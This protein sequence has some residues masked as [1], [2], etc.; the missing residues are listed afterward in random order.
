MPFPKCIWGCC[1]GFV[2]AW[3]AARQEGSRCFQPQWPA[4]LQPWYRCRVNGQLACLDLSAPALQPLLMPG[5]ELPRTVLEHDLGQ[6]LADINYFAELA[7]RKSAERLF[8][9]VPG[10]D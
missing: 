9:C 1:R 10:L 6:P 7:G 5:L 4:W 8:V 3:A 2:V